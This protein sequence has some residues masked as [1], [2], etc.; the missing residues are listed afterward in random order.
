[1]IRVPS[2][3]PCNDPR[4]RHP[5]C[6]DT[7]SVFSTPEA[8]RSAHGTPPSGSA[9]GTTPAHPFPQPPDL[10]VFQNQKSKKGKEETYLERVTDDAGC[11]NSTQ[12]DLYNVARQCVAPYMSPSLHIH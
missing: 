1:M 8:P 2:N 9:L 10:L 3:P 12:T 6:R 4:D 11:S 7:V 5:T